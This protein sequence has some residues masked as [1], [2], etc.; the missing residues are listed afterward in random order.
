MPFGLISPVSD[1]K[2]ED[3]LKSGKHTVIKT[4]K[5]SPPQENFHNSQMKMQQEEYLN[6]TYNFPRT[7][8]SGEK[9]N[10]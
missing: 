1:K 5:F 2:V 7:S 4:V 3:Q 9:K 8:T 10:S 6:G